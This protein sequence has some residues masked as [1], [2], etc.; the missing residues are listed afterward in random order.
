MKT[1]KLIKL[2]VGLLFAVAFA[3]NSYTTVDRGHVGVLT[4]FG[5][6][7]TS[8]LES[9]FHWVNP[10][11]DVETVNVQNSEHTFDG[12]DVPS[13]DKLLTDV[14]VTIKWRIDTSMA[15]ESLRD[16]GD[17]EALISTHLVPKARSVIRETGKTIAK[18]DDFFKEEVQAQMQSSIYDGLTVSL[19]AKGILIDEVL[20]RGIRLPKSVADGVIATKQRE[21]EGQKQIAEL[22]RFK[23]E[24]QQKVVLAETEALAAKQELIKRSTL[25]DAKAYE[26]LA[27]AKARAEAIKIEGEAIAK[28]PDLIKLRQ[29]E[30]WNGVMPRFM[31]GGSGSGANGGIGMLLSVNDNQ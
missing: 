19:A 3:L 10:L 26:V 23:T 29:I 5:K 22:A 16:T 18:A 27:E 30:Q 13:Q 20:I 17:K 4:L 6:V 28:T 31:M 21:I 12:V 15:A 1:S 14:D 7:N 2:V 24:Q 25:A 8:E 11:A 9:G